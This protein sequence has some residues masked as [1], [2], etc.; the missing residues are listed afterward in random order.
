M[1]Q[2]DSVVKQSISGIAQKNSV[3]HPPV[4]YKYYAFNEWTKDI[5]DKN[6]V[7][8]QS[9]DCF[10]DP[11]DS[12][13]AYIFEGPAEQRIS[14]LIELWQKGP[15]KGKTKDALYSQAA[16]C[17][18]SGRDVQEVLRTLGRSVERSRKRLGI[19]CMTEEEKNLLMWSHYAESHRGFCLGFSTSNHFFG[20]K[21]AWPIEE[22]HYR[23][24]RP[25]INFIDEH[26]E[27]KIVEAL[28]T[29]Y[30]RWQYEREWR[31]VDCE[32]GPGVQEYPPDALIEVILGSRIFPE[33]RN[34]IMNWCRV[35]DS[36]PSI[37][38]AEEMD[39]EFKL[40]LEPIKY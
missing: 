33:N 7:Y 37:Y 23:N 3:S 16:D 13:I 30:E 8:F 28:I 20:P 18:E 4:L 32:K 38:W 17:V 36:R 1:D 25:C 29:K 12:K 31:I 2:K 21:R 26:Y 24:D 40:K 39:R 14:R 27:K 22:K 11:F 6:E 15:A 35:R 34:K 19:F 10:N 5:F 9:P